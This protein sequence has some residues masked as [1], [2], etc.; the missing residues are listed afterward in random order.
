[1]L[2]NIEQA[3]SFASY[4]MQALRLGHPFSSGKAMDG[5]V[6]HLRKAGWVG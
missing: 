3:K 5:F 6:M 4:P 2:R 1:M